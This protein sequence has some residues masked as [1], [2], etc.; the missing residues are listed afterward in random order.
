MQPGL[1]PRQHRPRAVAG[2]YLSRH[3]VHGG[4]GSVAGVGA[5]GSLSVRRPV[6][7]I[8]TALGV[9]YVYHTLPGGGVEGGPGE[10]E[11]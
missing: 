4:W 1:I 3:C 11:A 8:E 7:D 2:G 5:R 10:R 6:T 9:V